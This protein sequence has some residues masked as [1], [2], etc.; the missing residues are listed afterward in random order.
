MGTPV[1]FDIKYANREE[2]R[3]PA[4]P[5]TFCL[6]KPEVSATN[7]VIWSRGF[8]TTMIF[9]LGEYSIMLFVTSLIIF[10]FVDKRSILDIPGFL[11]RPAVITTTS[12]LFVSL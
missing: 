12:L 7:V 8:V 6:G 10:P 11:G 9:G 3:I 5:I 4:C 1:F 2:S